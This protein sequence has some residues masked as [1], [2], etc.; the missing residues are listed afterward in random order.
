MEILRSFLTFL[1]A[2]KPVVASLN[3][4]CFFRLNQF[5][6]DLNWLKNLNEEVTGHEHAIPKL[7]GETDAAKEIVAQISVHLNIHTLR[8]HF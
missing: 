2:G 5:L 3:V 7:N 8:L 4:G 1:F 6:C